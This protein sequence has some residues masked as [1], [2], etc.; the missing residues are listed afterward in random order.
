MEETLGLPAIR[1]I[2]LLAPFGWL[3]AGWRDLMQAP[4]PLQG[5]QPPGPQRPVRRLLGWLEL[6]APWAQR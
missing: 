6:L 4:L 3:A 5:L 1:T 2:K